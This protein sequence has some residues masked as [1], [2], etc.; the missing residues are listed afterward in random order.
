[1][2]T[3]SSR[4]SS[5]ASDGALPDDFEFDQVNPNER[6]L[7]ADY[8]SI[9]NRRKWLI[10]GTV[11]AF[12]LAGLLITLF[13]TPLYK[14]SATLEIQR[15][16][17][18]F[19]QVKGDERTQT[20]AD[21]EFYETQY[22]LLSSKTL[23]ERVAR[24]L[25]LGDDPAFFKAFN[26]TPPENWYE[27][28]R[29]VQTTVIRQARWRTAGA[30][31]L[32]NMEVEPE[33][34]SRLVRIT[35]TSPDPELAKRV[36][37]AWSENFVETTLERRY[38]ASSYARKFL[39]ERLS[40]LRV[41]IDQSERALVGYAANQNIINIPGATD[42]QGGSAGER[43]LVADDLVNLNRSLGEATAE[44]VNAESRLAAVERTSGSQDSST[45]ST[46]RARRAELNADYA[47]LTQQFD[48]AYPPARALR[49]QIASI[50]AALRGESGRATDV[51][52]Q[53][54][55]AATARETALT[56]RVKQLT[57]RVLD[58][59]RR[60][61]Q[62]NILQREVDTNRQLYDALLQRY[63]EIGVAGG[64]GV[65]NI[66]VV[67]GAEVP[68]GPSSPRL[69]FNLALALVAG[70]VAG[71]ALALLFEQI[72]EGITDPI[73]IERLL[74]LPLIGVTPKLAEG[75]PVTALQDPKA[76]LTEAYST[77]T[78]NLGF[79]TSHG[80]PRTLAVTSA[81]PAEGKSSTSY[82][83]AR[84]LA[85]TNRR[86]LLIDADMRSPSIH[87]LLGIPLG[88]GLSNYL[89]GAEDVSAL[90]HPTDIDQLS[91]VTAGP[92]PPST[93]ELLSS[94]RLS[95]LFEA[96]TVNFD[97]IILDLPP[98]MGLADA[99]LIAS[100]VEGTLVV[101]AAHSTHKNVARL[102]TSRLRSAHAHILGVVLS[103]FDSKQASYGYGYGYG[104]G[105]GYGYG[106]QTIK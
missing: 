11:I 48:T 96:L 106:D 80:V 14:A 62:Y 49:A 104:Y 60:S 38:S 83:L 33:R 99:P 46:L 18:G 87:H 101:I 45:S 74:R 6:S 93:P 9:A 85:R 52:R 91:V 71:A 97:H 55:D 26:L 21:A 61:I 41:R 67:D 78:A 12:V 4:P 10:L 76:P 84:S 90:I 51:L 34:L 65:N 79:S 72:D 69:M 15:E 5:A 3:F 20:S 37:D 59:R 23:G 1:M 31:L 22:G 68:G 100:K 42:A 70:L 24:S 13:M 105:Q 94:D 17:S 92:Q 53:N 82:A 16:T 56:A 58:F 77:I 19:A 36:V 64:V 28:G 57:G 98:V 25:R 89:A 27:N 7:I 50:D 95:R 47:R 102:A 39:E 2:N 32:K 63:K 88:D 40:Q 30:L 81:R 54:L 8:L 75:S 66:S 29:P 43:S 44:R 35:F 86:V 73:D 103:M